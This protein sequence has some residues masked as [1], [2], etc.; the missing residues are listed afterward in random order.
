LAK[1]D[2]RRPQI[3][4]EAKVLDIRS[5]ASKELGIAWSWRDAAY[6]EVLQDAEGKP[7][8][9][10]LGKFNRSPVTAK[11]NALV[12]SGTAKVLANPNV[13]ALEGEPC[14]IFIGDEFKYVINIQQTTTG[15]NVT[16]ETARVGVQL[17]SVSRISSDGFI[18]MDLHPE[19]SV[20]KSFLQIPQLGLAFPEMSRRYVDSTI[21]VKDGE[22]IVIGG[23]ITEEERESISGLPI[24]RDLPIIGRLFETKSKSRVHSEVLVFI[25]P[26]ILTDT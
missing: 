6:S 2:V 9:I 19:V 10:T 12:E 14:S 18:T 3:L 13:L 8:A 5:D 1:V 25:T 21:R 11:V 23:L 17:H 4:I 20:I 15:I 26:R 22:T 24:L 16:T 7:V